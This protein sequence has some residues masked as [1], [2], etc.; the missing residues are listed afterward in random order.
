MLILLYGELGLQR[1]VASAEIKK[2]YRELAREYHPDMQ[3]G[4]AVSE[5]KAAE[6]KFKKTA[7]AYKTLEK[8]YNSSSSSPMAR[9]IDSARIEGLFKGIISS[10]ERGIERFITKLSQEETFP[11]IKDKIIKKVK[12]A[13]KKEWGRV[14]A[15]S[16][17]APLYLPPVLVTVVGLGMSGKTTAVKGIKKLLE[18]VIED[19]IKEVIGARIKLKIARIEFDD[20][21]LPKDR[22]A[23]YIIE[24]H[25]PTEEVE[26]KFEIEHVF[27]KYMRRVFI[28]HLP[29]EQPI[30]DSVTQG[31][32]RFENRNGRLVIHSGKTIDKEGGVWRNEIRV[33]EAD[34]AF[35]PVL[36][37]YWWHYR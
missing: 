5:K 33:V 18:E 3:N 4:K 37:Y 15:G 16:K 22:R 2:R 31:R 36:E 32:I 29:G 13:I 7:Q 14:K 21:M 30:Y 35:G 25:N 17:G 34:W 11:L 24:P 8:Y 1:G 9:V 10:Y 23:L 12:A 26:Q 6:E 19:I 27:K 28:D 20:C